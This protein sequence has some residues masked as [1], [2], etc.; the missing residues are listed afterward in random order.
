MS[1]V[2]GDAAKTVDV[3]ASLLSTVLLTIFIL[4]IFLLLLSILAHD[5]ADLED[6]LFITIHR[7]ICTLSVQRTMI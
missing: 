5:I 4:R 1:N 6:S 3:E 7:A 2:V